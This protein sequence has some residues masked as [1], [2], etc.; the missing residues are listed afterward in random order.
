M[1]KSNKKKYLLVIFL[2]L[3][4]LILIFNSVRSIKIGHQTNSTDMN[5]NAIVTNIWLNDVSKL[6]K[7]KQNNIKYL[8]IDIGDTSLNGQIITPKKEIVDF[9]NFINKYEKKSGYDFNLLPYSEIILDKYNLEA[10]D[11]Q[12]NLIEDYIYLNKIGYDGIL[13]DIEKIPLNQREEYLACLGNL[14]RKL[15][16]QLNDEQSELIKNSIKEPR[17]HIAHR[18]L[19]IKTSIKP[20]GELLP[21]II[22][23]SDIDKVENVR[24]PSQYA[25][26]EVGIICSVYSKIKGLIFVVY[27]K[28]KDLVQVYQ[29]TF[30]DINEIQKELKNRID[31]I[32]KA[33]KGMEL[34]SV[35]FCP[36]FMC[37]NKC[38]IYKKCFP[39]KN[40][41]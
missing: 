36:D 17:M 8:I 37:D 2:L 21:Y 31:L 30:K 5:K 11:F 3:I 14:I 24:G 23:K 35:D 38:P 6:D 13:I 18:W 27:P 33:V 22:K 34:L 4:N 28:L 15:Q 25:V 32:E 7:F 10:Y 16:M 20:D 39:E 40:K 41:N 19:D 26:A 29:V 12:K 1:H 9:I